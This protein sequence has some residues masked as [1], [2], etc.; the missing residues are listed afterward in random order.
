[1]LSLKKN[2]FFVFIKEVSMKFFY[3]NNHGG[4]NF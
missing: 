1:M 4:E 2:K 3:S